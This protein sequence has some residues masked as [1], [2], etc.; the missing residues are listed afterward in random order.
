MELYTPANVKIN[1]SVYFD[2]DPKYLLGVF[3][4]NISPGIGVPGMMFIDPTSPIATA[5]FSIS[6]NQAAVIQAEIN[7]TIGN[8]PF[9]DVMSGSSQGQLT[10][11]C[12][13][14]VEMVLNGGA[15]MHLGLLSQRICLV[16]LPNDKCVQ[17]G[18]M[19]TCQHRKWWPFL[20]E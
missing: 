15:F 20:K 13:T 4:R 8:A 1:K 12:A 3:T 6:A 9:Y 10:Y 16:R 2:A 17:R 5:S 19:C 18:A 11:D 7:S 14:W